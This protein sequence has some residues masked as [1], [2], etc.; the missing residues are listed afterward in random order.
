M[1]ITKGEPTRGR[2]KGESGMGTKNTFFLEVIE[3]F[4]TTGREILHRIPEEGS[5]EIKWGAQLTV[6][7]SQT[8]VLFYQGRAY[9]A[10]GPGRHTLKTANLPI[11]TKILSAPWGFTSPLRAEVVFVNRKVF[12]NLRWGTRDP[13]AFK[14]SRLGLVRLRA[15]GVFNIRVAQP[16]L[17]INALAGTQGTF[18]TEDVEEYLS[19]VIVSRLND[20]LGATV[21]TLFDLPGTY[22]A[23][24]DGLETTLERDF[25]G[26]GLEL[27]NL[28]IES[29]TPPEEVQRAIDDKGRMSLFD[30]INKLMQMKA[31]MSMEKAS[32]ARGEA[33]GGMGLG[34]GLLLPGLLSA[35][36]GQARAAG[37]A[38][39]SAGEVP[40]CPGCTHPVPATARFCP[41]CGRELLLFAR[42]AQCAKSLPPDARFCPACGTAAASKPATKAC[43]SC[44]MENLHGSVY[45]NRCGEKLA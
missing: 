14:D 24:S 35:G 23:M 34:M 30:D 11:V 21:D 36:M 43:A 6:R 39:G 8:G 10:F 20:H 28:Y 18:S 32:D 9:D 13:V 38:G 29:I 16:V 31:A 22:D 26:F 17:F 12:T 40:V 19:R 25:E 45:C 27:Q 44:G 15:F 1:P 3:W 33:A 7:E 41:S 2:M 42:C 4:D 5:G 37:D